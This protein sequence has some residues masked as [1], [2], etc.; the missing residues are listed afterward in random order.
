MQLAIKN[1]Q[2][3]I[4]MLKQAKIIGKDEEMRDEGENDE[5]HELLKQVWNVEV[6][7]Q[8]LRDYS[9]DVDKMPLGVLKH[10]KVKK[11]NAILSAITRLLSQTGGKS[12]DRE[13][14]LTD[15][16]TDF[17]QTLPFDFGVKRPALIDHLIRVK[18]KARMLE[19]INDI[20]ITEQ[21]LLNS[22]NDMKSDTGKTLKNELLAN[23]Q[24]L[25][26]DDKVFE[27]IYTAIQNTHDPSVKVAVRNIF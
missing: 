20:C 14:K 1:Q 17:Y 24:L 15:L 7:K 10:D 25:P 18:E 23:V 22:M 12:A 16:T 19:V 9:L 6:Y 27:Q 11:C 26:R 2:E 3:L 13:Q 21:C 4:H 8:T 5:M